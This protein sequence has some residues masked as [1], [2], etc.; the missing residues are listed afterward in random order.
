MRKK[1]ALLIMLITAGVSLG[2]VDLVT[3]PS[4][5]LQLCGYDAGSGGE[6]ADTEGRS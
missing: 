5:D 2:A 1:V 3:L 6:G 4:Y